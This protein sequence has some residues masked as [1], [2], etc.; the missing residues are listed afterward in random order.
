MT[1]LNTTEVRNHVNAMVNKLK[2]KFPNH[3]GATPANTPEFVIVLDTET[4]GFMPNALT[5]KTNPETKL[6]QVIELAAIVISVPEKK[7]VDSFQSYFQYDPEFSWEA[8]AENIHKLSQDFL[9]DKPTLAEGLQNFYQKMRPYSF[10]DSKRGKEYLQ[11]G[12]HNPAFD[13]EQ[14]QLATAVMQQKSGFKPQASIIYRM[15]DQFTLG[16]LVGLTD[17]TEQRLSMGI[18][19][20]QHHQAIWDTMASA[21]MYLFFL[22]GSE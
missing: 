14:L 19:P 3:Q 1:S 17:S 13:Y 5:L 2:L 8:E 22:Q 12:C 15:V 11:C 18:D 7:V 6:P 20:A 4:T 10:I 16:H 9:A 21:A